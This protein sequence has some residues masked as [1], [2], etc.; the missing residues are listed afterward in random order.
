MGN[1]FRLP[2]PIDGFSQSNYVPETLE[3]GGVGVYLLIQI[4]MGLCLLMQSACLAYG[5]P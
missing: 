3:G 4:M 1:S 2:T 5:K